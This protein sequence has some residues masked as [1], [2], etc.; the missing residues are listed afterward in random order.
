M[1]FAGGGGRR[2]QELHFSS[3]DPKSRVKGKETWK[4]DTQILLFTYHELGSGHQPQT[5]IQQ[6]IPHCTY[7]DTHTT[8]RQT[9]IYKQHTQHIQTH[10]N[11]LKLPTNHRYTCK[12]QIHTYRHR[13]LSTTVQNTWLRSLHANHTHHMDIHIN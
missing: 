5:D 6:Y 8:Y 2:S 13:H 11:A 4:A 9:T 10:N 1:K 12:M 3:V 7:I